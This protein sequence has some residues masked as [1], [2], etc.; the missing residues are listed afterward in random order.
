[1]QAWQS[2]LDLAPDD[3]RAATQLTQAKRELERAAAY[4][5]AIQDAE[6]GRWQAAL[7]G[8]KRLQAQSPGYRDIDACIAAA[9]LQLADD[10]QR[11]ETASRTAR[12][13]EMRR[14]AEAAMQASAWAT[15]VEQW[16]SLLKLEPADADAKAQL[17]E[18]RR[19]S[20]AAGL[21]ASAA[22]YLAAGQAAE[23]LQAFRT[24]RNQFGRYLDVDARIAGLE[25][26]AQP[27]PEAV[28]ARNRRRVAWALAGAGMLLAIVLA[29]ILI[30]RLSGS[31]NVAPVSAP[32]T[33]ASGLAAVWPTENATEAP[34]TATQLSSPAAP[35]LP[36]AAVV[37]AR[38]TEVRSTSTL[39]PPTPEP[40][41]SRAAA[42]AL[43]LTPTSQ[44][45]ATLTAMPA[46]TPTSTLTRTSVPLKT[47]TRTVLKPS[48][49][50]VKRPSATPGIL[51]APGL[52][53]PED[54]VASNG[55]TTFVWQW[56]GPALSQDQGF[57]IRL[58]K[59]GQ[60]DHYGA[61]EIIPATARQ[62]QVNLA[63]S[64]GWQQ[65]GNG[66]YWWTVAAVQRE[67]YRRVGNEAP[68]RAIEVNISAGEGSS[69]STIVPPPP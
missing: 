16:L 29:I 61:S 3:E 65:G 62:A 31:G 50:P 49:T 67:P 5:Q 22:K 51:V 2:V 32:P 40:R 34:P 8:F 28:R 58:W 1:V 12:A 44:A 42:F 56:S 63:G 14:A 57:E 20:E 59:E 25:A 47:A 64:Y 60:P 11:A 39:A 10:V 45:S 41:K 68:P 17:A 35:S 33:A 26:M 53:S 37:A 54:R 18:A 46:P 13:R 52:V 48:A 23:A 36:A 4:T 6:A 38:S 9:E 24:L 21:Y 43:S 15:A 55:V 69:A 19:Q 27:N 66:R 30:P 7:A